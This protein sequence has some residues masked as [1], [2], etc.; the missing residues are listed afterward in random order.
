[1][2]LTQ[3]YYFSFED[4]LLW[5]RLDTDIKT[6]G[7]HGRELSGLQPC[8]PLQVLLSGKV[9][10]FHSY[11]WLLFGTRLLS[12]MSSV[13]ATRPEPL[14]SETVRKVRSQICPADSRLTFKLEG[15]GGHAHGWTPPREDGSRGKCAVVLQEPCLPV[16]PHRG[17]SGHSRIPV[18]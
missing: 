11:L 14:I 2:Y 18:P 4:S 13:S 16:M 10:Q 7:N 9:S 5:K 1:M 8:L 3:F 17:T 12:L 6:K 15:C